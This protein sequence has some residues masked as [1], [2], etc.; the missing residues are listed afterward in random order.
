M[1][2]ILWFVAS[3]I[4]ASIIVALGLG[5][6]ISERLPE[7]IRRRPTSLSAPLPVHGRWY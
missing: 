2:V 5:R 3:W 1:S 7:E 4:I 6:L